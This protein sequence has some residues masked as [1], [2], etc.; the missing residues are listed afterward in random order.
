[1]GSTD[2]NIPEVPNEEYVV[3]GNEERN[4]D[5]IDPTIQGI[6]AANLANTIPKVM[7]EDQALIKNK[8]RNDN[9]MDC[10]NQGIRTYT[11]PKRSPNTRSDDFL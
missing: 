5:Q 10:E 6:E 4:D 3:M 11:R 2:N 1:M 7:K 9:Q 8:E